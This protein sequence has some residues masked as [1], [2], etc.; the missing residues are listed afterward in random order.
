MNLKLDCKSF[1]LELQIAET[2]QGFKSFSYP[3]GKLSL[4]SSVPNPV[5]HP[6]KLKSKG[7]NAGESATRRVSFSADGRPPERAAWG[8]WNKL[9]EFLDSTAAG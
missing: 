7:W 6:S 1:C 9:Q 5:T 3:R 2:T 8:T 4:P